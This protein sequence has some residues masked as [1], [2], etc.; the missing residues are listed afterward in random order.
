MSSPLLMD[1]RGWVWEG[2]WKGGSG[3]YQAPRKKEMHAG[4]LVSLE[5]EKGYSESPAY[6]HVREDPSRPEL[7]IDRALYTSV[8]PHLTSEHP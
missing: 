7:L 4:K 1:G 2:G 3:S 6:G 5:G 8:G